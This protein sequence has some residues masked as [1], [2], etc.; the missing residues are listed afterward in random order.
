MGKKVIFTKDFAGR[1]KGDEDEF[2]SAVANTLV[3]HDKVAKYA[4][5]K[6]QSALENLEKEEHKR[7]AARQKKI[8][9]DKAK[10]VKAENKRLAANAKAQE[11]KVKAEEALIEKYGT[12]K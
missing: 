1:E 10:I 7:E 12:K 3:R 4:D 2:D 6:Q 8:K 9:A 11:D 5:E